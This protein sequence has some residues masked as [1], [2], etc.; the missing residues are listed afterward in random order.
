[1]MDSYWTAM[2]NWYMAIVSLSLVV[3][4]SVKL[5]HHSCINKL[6]LKDRSTGIPTD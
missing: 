2:K 4:S 3:V 1:M 6:T 5:S